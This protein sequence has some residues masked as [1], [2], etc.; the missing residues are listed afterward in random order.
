MK[1]LHFLFIIMIFGAG[2]AKAEDVATYEGET[3]LGCRNI[4]N[5]NIF[6]ND[7]NDYGTIKAGFVY[8]PGGC[9][10]LPQ[11]DRKYLKQENGE[12][13]EMNTIE[14][15]AVDILEGQA[16]QAAKDAR[17]A[18]LEVTQEEALTALIQVI[19]VRLPAGQK[20][21]KQ[22]LVDKIKANR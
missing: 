3:Y 12:I 8:L 15:A 9:S 7:P 19:N 5:T 16:E 18:R 11:V 6:L 13:V 2:L 1:T 22:E 10:S 14:K 17:Y 20:I 4:G 21:T